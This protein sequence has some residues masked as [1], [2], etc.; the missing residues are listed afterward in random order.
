[1]AHKFAAEKAVTVVHDIDMQVGR[2]GVLT[3]IARLQPVTVGGVVVS[4]ATLHNADWLA[5]K[6]VRCGD[7]VVVR[8]AGM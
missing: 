1:M 8:R 4:N 5:E 7:T 3:P 2:S 6:D